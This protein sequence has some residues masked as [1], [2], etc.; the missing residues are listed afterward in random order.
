MSVSK[1]VSFIEDEHRYEDLR[2]SALNEV[3]PSKLQD[4]HERMMQH[5]VCRA[6]KTVE[7]EWGSPPAHFAFFVMGS[8][9][10]L[11][12]SYYSDQDHGIVYDDDSNEFEDYFMRLGGEI[13]SELKAAGYEECDGK[14]M[15]STKRW[16]KSRTEWQKQI[17]Q[18]V[19]EDTW[20]TLR[21]VLTLADARHFMGE[22]NYIIELKERLQH[23]LKTKPDLLKRLTEN[24]GRVKKGIG[25]FGQLLTEPKGIHQGKFD[26]KQTVLF[27]YVNGLRLLAL[28]ENIM[29]TSTLERM[30]KLPAAYGH[31]KSHQLSFQELLTH[32]L[33]FQRG[34]KEYA[35]I[36]FVD[37]DRLSSSDKQRLK[38][39][40]R[41]GHE[42]YQYIENVLMKG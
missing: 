23:H 1:K 5:A 7:S 31:I 37:V 10:R 22:A 25:F 15:A 6:L 3:K 13:T 28:K 38:E 12:Q 14:V 17:D 29:A 16:C 4:I 30:K 2:Q 36:H 33:S 42:L 21:Y 18:W 20:E 8:A 11:E 19:Q 32:R 39:W 35:G 24:T 40:V 26:L 34:H 27:P 9:G 41:E